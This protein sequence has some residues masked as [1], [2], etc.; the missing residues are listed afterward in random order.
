MTG[1]PMQGGWQYEQHSGHKKSLHTEMSSVPELHIYTLFGV[2]TDSGNKEKKQEYG[3]GMV[4]SRS[5]ARFFSRFIVTSS[6]PLVCVL[7]CASSVR[8]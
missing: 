2:N 7:I 5:V 6:C 3:G 1:C 8:R 4:V